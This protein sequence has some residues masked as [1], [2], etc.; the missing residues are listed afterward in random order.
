[1]KEL[2]GVTDIHTHAGGIDLF[3]L[4]KLRTP[5]TQS[6]KDLVLKAKL[7]H[8]FHV[9]AFPMPMPL[10]YDAIKIVQHQIWEP[11]GLEKFPYE[12]TNNAL[13]YESSI[14][15]EDIVLPFMAI[16]PKEKVSEQIAF[17]DKAFSSHQ[18]YGLK[19]HTRATDTNATDLINSPIVEL[20]KNYNAPILI[21]SHSKAETTSALRILEFAEYHQ[22]IRVCVAHLADLDKDILSQIASSPNVYVDCTPFLNLCK[23]AYERNFDRISENIFETDYSNPA[24]CLVDLSNVLP[25][26]LLW[27]T[28]EPWTTASNQEGK[29][30][31]K[32]SYENECAVIRNIVEM[33]YIHVKEAITQRNTSRFLF[34]HSSL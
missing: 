9:V 4:I 12:L 31:A 13:L 10:Y 1:M 34:G 2:L 17:L 15:G 33:G 6:V 5:I 20:L 16:H 18:A 21:H 32:F 24:K 19:L 14:F 29:V 25:G 22:D 30:Y 3:N 27:G 23:F 11:S 26:K 7:N 8:V 28:D